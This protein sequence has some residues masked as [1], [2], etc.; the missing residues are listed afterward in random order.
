MLNLRLDRSHSAP[1]PI[2]TEAGAPNRNAQARHASG[3]S[4][5]SGAPHL[6]IVDRVL[7]VRPD[8]ELHLADTAATRRDACDLIAKMY[9]TRGYRWDCDGELPA[10]PN[11]YTFAVKTKGILVGTLT[12]AFEATNGMLRADE[13]FAQEITERRRDGARVCEITWFAFDAQHGTRAL[14]AT[15]FYFVHLFARTLHHASEMFIEVNPRHA[16]FYLRSLDFRRVGAA[17]ECERVG[18]PAILLKLDLVHADR[19]IEL[20]GGRRELGGRTLY[21]LFP[22]AQERK[23]AHRRVVAAGLEAHLHM[24]PVAGRYASPP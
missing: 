23:A 7:L 14:L 11:A 13:L 22:D 10:W 21:P 9:A 24:H 3:R 20:L 6:R 12:L 4:S 15:L 18:A 16:G 17:R 19:Q 2:N 5:N 1:V 8:F